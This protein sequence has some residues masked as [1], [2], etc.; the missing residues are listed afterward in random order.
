MPCI[1][2]HEHIWPE[3]FVARLRERRS[4]PWLDGDTLHLAGEQPCPVDVA[5]DPLQSR[6]DELDAAGIDIGI[7]SLQ[8][9]LGLDA[10]PEPERADLARVWQG[11]VDELVSAANGR[12]VALAADPFDE[13]FPGAVLGAPALIALDDVALALDALERRGAFLFVHPGP[14]A[15]PPGAAPA[16][17]PAVVDYTAQ[18]QAAY[19]MWLA[20]GSER[21]PRLRI[22]FAILAGGGPFQLERLH[23]R[24]VGS[25]ATLHPNVF[26]DIASYGRRGL[27]LCLQAY[28][29]EQLVFGT[30]I[31][32][33]DAYE[34]LRAARGFG[35]SVAKYIMDTNPSQLIA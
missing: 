16:W 31:P 21:W 11:A 20:Q 26:F 22:V 34:S 4:P 24:G 23:S 33:I 12:L 8:P 28:G 3:R 10:L 35:D 19:A 7:V 17:W 15:A 30:D 9:T 1:D 2:V 5:G 6:L 25:R 14:A 27:E 18:M 29:V 13:R 32:V